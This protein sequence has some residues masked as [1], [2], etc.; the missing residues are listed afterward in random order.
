MTE[1]TW[2]IDVD[3][4][5]DGP[6]SDD[7]LDTLVDAVEPLYGAVSLSRSGK[8]LGLSI[9]VE[10]RD[11]WQA[12]ELGKSFL[13]GT[14]ADLLNHPVVRSFRVLDEPTREKENTRPQFPELISVPDIADLLGVTR[15]AA[16]K[17]TLKVDFPKPLLTPRTGPLWARAAVEAWSENTQPRPGR[18]A[19]S[20]G[21]VSVSDKREP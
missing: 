13:V 18:V 7:A 1:A 3:L 19:G 10:A 4:A 17:H 12:L 2:F 16:R 8:D 20:G 9:A 6:V 5:I 14:I 21:S 15:Q 11:Y